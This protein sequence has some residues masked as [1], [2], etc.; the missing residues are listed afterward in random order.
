MQCPN[1]RK[2]ESGR[3]LFA[4]GSAHSI[5]ETSARD[6]MP[7]EGPHDLPYSRRPFGFH[8][9][10]FS[11]FTVHSSIEEAEPSLN[12]SS[13]FR[14]NEQVPN[15]NLHH[16]LNSISSPRN[17]L[18]ANNM[19]HPSWGWNCHFVPYNADTD[20]IDRV[21]WDPHRSPH[22]QADAI[23]IPPSFLHPLHY[24]Q[25]RFSGARS[26]PMGLP[27][28]T[29]RPNHHGSRGFYIHEPEASYNYTH[30]TDVP[31]IRGSFHHH[32]NHSSS[33]RTHWS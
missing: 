12:T 18:R 14:P 9:C 20:I 17:N 16:P 1:C 8:W 33:N 6:W 28:V 19:Q 5:S 10:P 23:A 21:N 24:T 11:G 3:W 13:Y 31:I 2:V 27:P 7:N 25:Q 32:H 29:S 15:S 22:T 4:D 30:E 26:L